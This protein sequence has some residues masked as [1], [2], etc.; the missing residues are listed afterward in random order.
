M[1]PKTMGWLVHAGA[2]GYIPAMEFLVLT[3]LANI[4][5]FLC[6]RAFPMLGMRTFHAITVN[7]CV[8]VVMGLI[9]LALDPKA[10][11]GTTFSINQPP[12]WLYIGLVLGSLFIGSFYLIALTSQR[13]GVSVA[14]IATK[15]SLAVPVAFSLFVFKIETE[16][17][18]TINYLGLLLAI[19]AVVLSSM[20]PHKAKDTVAANKR[21]R[22][23]ALL[24]PLVVFFIAGGMDT[25][26]NYTNYAYL[27]PADEAVFPIFLFGMAAITGITTLLIQRKR[28]H[29][30]SV[31]G[32]IMLGVPNY[33]SIYL[34]LR[35]LRA[36]NNNGAFVY[37][38]LNIGIIVGSTLLA[39][40][41]FKER[42]HWINWLG[43]ALAVGVIV[44][45]A[46]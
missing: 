36:Y 3:T 17:F 8:C 31:L 39:L 7:Y 40:W 20:Q 19:P 43:L 42:L 41:L 6:F 18:S 10:L 29:L 4:A 28:I 9:V 38:V 30:R 37:P 2:R 45:M 25:T 22:G 33:F 5:I 27:T 1:A 32:G 35:T 34:M 15:M 23:L 24:L 11:Q 21:M 13:L 44:L 14:T 46:L 26:L 16:S 12:T